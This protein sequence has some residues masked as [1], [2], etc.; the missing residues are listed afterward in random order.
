MSRVGKT[1]AP[2]ASLVGGRS[3]AEA[4]G[5]A[6]IGPTEPIAPRFLTLAVDAF[7]GGY[8]GLDVAYGCARELRGTGAP[9]NTRGPG[10][11]QF[12]C[13]TIRM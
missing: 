3:P 2:L 9:P 13:G 1:S 6:V 12:G 4:T 7:V 11:A 5:L 8:D 10:T